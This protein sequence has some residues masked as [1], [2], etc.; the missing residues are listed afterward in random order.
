M[1]IL[2]MIISGSI[3]TIFNKIMQKLKGLE[4][5]FEQHQWIITFGMFQ[6]ELVSIFFYIYILYKRKK[7]EELDENKLIENNKESEKRPPVPT[8]LIFAISALC[9][10]LGTTINTFGLTYLTTSMFQMM[11]GLELFF[12]CLWSKLFLKNPIY[13]HAILGIGTLIFG[14]S[15]VGLNAILNDKKSVA[16]NP[17]VGIILLCTSQFFSSTQYV[18]QEKF[19]KSY[20]VHPFQLVG[21]EGLW[22]FCM[23]TIILIIFQ[24]I[25]CDDWI[26]ALKDGICFK[27]NKNK[28]HMEDTIFA[29]KQ[30]GDNVAILI[31]YIFL[32]YIQNVGILVN[33]FFLY[34]ILC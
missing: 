28:Y 22:G 1:L 23:Y 21:F 26:D 25:P 34:N 11:R 6:G 9:D 18:I 20:D 8:N 19:I 33:K 5:L 27:D 13:R 2:L 31:L 10:L 14:L 7:Q 3:N 12:V 24:F 29:F 17:V 16:R 15:L 32:I 30:M 4:V